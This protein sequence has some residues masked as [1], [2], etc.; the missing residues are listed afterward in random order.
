MDIDIDFADRSS[1]LNVIKHVPASKMT[2]ID[3][4]PH[5]VGVYLHHVPIDPDTQRCSLDYNEAERRGYF[6][7]DFLNLSVYD[8]VEDERHLDRLLNAE[9]EW[10]LLLERNI[11]ETLF[12]LGSE[13]AFKAL[14]KIKPTTMEELAICI[15]LFRPGKAYLLER[16]MAEIKKEIWK[17]VSSYYFKKP[18]AFSYAAVIIVQLNLLCDQATN[19]EI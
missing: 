12:H 14:K 13:I 6:K 15:A 7:I 10:D 3:L 4:L 17:P 1:A 5:N 9:P 2:D 19:C 8:L 16:D 18:H 11:S